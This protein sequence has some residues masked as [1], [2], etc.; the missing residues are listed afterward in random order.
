MSQ[1]PRNKIRFS[2]AK[3]T[4]IEMLINQRFFN[5]EGF[6]QI[7][8]KTFKINISK[9]EIIV[10]LQSIEFFFAIT[11]FSLVMVFQ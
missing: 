3:K 9:K 7:D 6:N 1:R 11:D 4:E 8:I 2:K 10:V 5:E